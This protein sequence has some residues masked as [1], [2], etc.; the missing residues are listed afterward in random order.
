[1][2]PC[3]RCAYVKLCERRVLLAASVVIDL[4]ATPA[5]S[6]PA[7]ITD[8][9]GTAF[10]A[11]TTAG[12]GR[13]LWKSDGTANG[14]VLVKDVWPG[15]A[16]SEPR[17]L[18]NISGTLYFIASMGPERWELWKSDGTANGTVR[19]SGSV[20]LFRTGIPDQP[21][22]EYNGAIYFRGSGTDG[23]GLELWRTD[24]TGAGTELVKDIYPGGDS[25]PQ[26]LTVYGGELYFTA[27]TTP[28]WPELWKTDGTKAG[29]VRVTDANGSPIGR[30]SSLLHAADLVFFIS[31]GSLWRTDGTEAGT[32]ALA[33]SDGSIGFTQM[34]SVG[35][36]LFLTSADGGSGSSVW[37]S[38]GTVAGTRRIIDFR[39]SELDRGYVS[40]LTNVNGTLFFRVGGNGRAELWKS[41]RVG[42]VPLESFAVTSENP[43]PTR[44]TN[45]GGRLY[46]AA[47]TPDA[48]V[49]LWTTDGT[50]GGARRVKD[51]L[52]GRPGHFPS[53]SPTSAVPHTSPRRSPT[54]AGSCGEATDRRRARPW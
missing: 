34:E 52:P 40:E 49:E 25:L 19:V 39:S 10:F 22:V 28:V 42:T 27:E 47:Y 31:G 12:T 1:M 48:G 50:P 30:S 14:T 33:A 38:D 16:S 23:S 46:F 20:N 6:Y 54:S 21:A 5:D 18:A 53:T 4:D 15:P 43:A 45:I 26:G 35:D 51:I 29:T 17:A 36:R 37:V 41:D 11:A 32:F 9:N 3:R 2:H 8:V 44:L 13:E 7:S 24:G